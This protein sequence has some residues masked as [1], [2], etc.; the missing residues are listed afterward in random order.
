[1]MLGLPD[2]G[3]DPRAMTRRRQQAAR[4][5]AARDPRVGS[6]AATLAAVMRQAAGLAARGRSDAAVA[7]WRR[8][9][10]LAPDYAPAHHHLG[11]VLTD[12]GRHMDGLKHH[13]EAFRHHRGRPAYRQALATALPEATT[14]RFASIIVREGPVCPNHRAF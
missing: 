10:E 4:K 9:L 13:F 3:R 6:A 1:M 7:A 2:A 12:R 8:A 11:R 5:A 14:R